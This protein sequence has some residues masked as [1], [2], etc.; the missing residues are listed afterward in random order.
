MVG[1]KRA[2]SIRRIAETLIKR[3]PD[4]FASDFKE[5]KDLISKMMTF[6][7]MTVR[8]QVAGY[9]T[10]TTQQTASES[11]LEDEEHEKEEA[12]TIS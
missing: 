8:N 10:R 9:I 4:G 6:P 12:S 1:K 7:S 3:R 2:V 11:Q 5:N